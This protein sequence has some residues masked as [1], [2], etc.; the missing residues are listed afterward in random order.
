VHHEGSSLIG[1][2]HMQ[3]ITGSDEQAKDRQWWEKQ[4]QRKEFIKLAKVPQTK[5][6]SASHGT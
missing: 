5:T 4:T 1:F 3:V 2:S 6:F